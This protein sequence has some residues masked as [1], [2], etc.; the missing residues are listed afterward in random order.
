VKSSCAQERKDKRYIKKKKGNKEQISLI[1][2]ILLTMQML[3]ETHRED[4]PHTREIQKKDT[5]T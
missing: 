5:R 2:G 4:A 1:P 3:V